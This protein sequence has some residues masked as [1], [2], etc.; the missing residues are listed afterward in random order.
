M[1]KNLGLIILIGLMVVITVFLSYIV[2]SKQNINKKNE[3]NISKGEVIKF[4]K[5]DIEVTVLN[6]ASTLCEN[7]DTCI[8]PGEI[9]VSLKVDYNDNIINYT[10][11][12]TSN[13][14]ERIKKSNYYR[15]N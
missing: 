7:K 11:K 3:F 14:V 1:K 8:S 6:V 5:Y 4:D 10:L 13:P 15:K 12:T 9:E 2:V